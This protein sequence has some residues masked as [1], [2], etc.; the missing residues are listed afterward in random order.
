[1]RWEVWL[2]GEDGTLAC[3]R[4]KLPIS[5]ARLTIRAMGSGTDDAKAKQSIERSE[6]KKGACHCDACPCPPVF[7]HS[8]ASLAFVR[9]IACWQS[10]TRFA[11]SCVVTSGIHVG[12][13]HSSCQMNPREE[14]ECIHMAVDTRHPAPINCPPGRQEFPRSTPHVLASTLPLF[15]CVYP[16]RECCSTT[17]RDIGFAPAMPP[18]RQRQ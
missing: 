4:L 12:D 13:H 9:Q 1:V 2:R 3:A 16:D 15:T 10:S 18:E 14:G 8:V 5:C 7:E 6:G 17:W 11:K